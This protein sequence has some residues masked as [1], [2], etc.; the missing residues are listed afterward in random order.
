MNSLHCNKAVFGNRV[1]H[2]AGVYQR[3]S[4]WA[5]GLP[6]IPGRLPPSAHPLGCCCSCSCCC[7]CCCC[8]LPTSPSPHPLGPAFSLLL[9]ISSAGGTTPTF[10]SHNSN[11]FVV[12]I[13]IIFCHHFDQTPSGVKPKKYLR[14][15]FS[16]K[17]S[18][19]PPTWRWDLK[20]MV[21]LV[22]SAAL[23][24]IV[25][26]LV[27]RR[28][29][30]WGGHVENWHKPW[31]WSADGGPSPLVGTF[32]QKGHLVFF[33]LWFNL[34]ALIASP[35]HLL[36][37]LIWQDWTSQNGQKTQFVIPWF[38][39][40]GNFGRIQL[41]GQFGGRFQTK[42]HLSFLSQVSAI[43]TPRRGTSHSI[44]NWSPRT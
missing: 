11:S 38:F 20:R 7:C 3:S 35:L 14:V 44:E 36:M 18:R 19:Q 31:V 26:N 30:P 43:F 6:C 41:G 40:A 33:T 24:L 8:R 39:A 16:H 37:I 4:S 10:F 2:Q 28:I 1:F 29:L 5:F 9:A 32:R 27:D 12:T 25:T 21:S 13:F 34:T 17:K 42:N 22:W 23:P 15:F